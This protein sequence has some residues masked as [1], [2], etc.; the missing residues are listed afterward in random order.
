M[1]I[2]KVRKD[3]EIDTIFSKTLHVLGHAEFFEPIGN[4]LHRQPR[5]ELPATSRAASLAILHEKL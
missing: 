5:A 3:R 2:R 1:Q 4:L